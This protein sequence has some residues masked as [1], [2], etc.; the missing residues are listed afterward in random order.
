MREHTLNAAGPRPVESGI[1]TSKLGVL[2]NSLLAVAKLVTGFLGNSYALI[3]DGIESF[4]DIFSSLIVWGGLRVSEK[5]ADAEHPYGH[6]KAETI[7]ALI[8]SNMLLGA[9]ILICVQSVREIRTPHHAPAW[10]TLPVLVA[11]ILI[12][13]GLFRYALRVSQKLG[14]SAL[15]TDAW[16]H[17][18]DALTSAAAFVGIS[19][20]LV[21]G[22]GYESADDWAALGAAGVIAWNGI[23]LLRASIDELMDVTVPGHIIGDVQTLASNIDGVVSVEKCRIRKVGLHL[24]MD[25]HV[26]V[27]GSL[28]VREGHLIS[29]RVKDALL[30]CPHRI[31]DVTIHIEPDQ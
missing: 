24:A 14:S 7:A 6:G 23:R 4:A 15:R 17:R 8:V 29:H 3:A 11:I 26:R 30:A 12:K 18:S 2:V 21:G 28:S 13:E 5:P 22:A 25:L 27:P 31:G 9:A 20:A 16:H 19:I 1:L 10:Y